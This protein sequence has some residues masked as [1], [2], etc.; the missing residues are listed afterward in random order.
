MI[1]IRNM[2]THDS[3]GEGFLDSYGMGVSPDS[4][5]SIWEDFTTSLP[6]H[7]WLEVIPF[8]SAEDS[9]VIRLTYTE[10][11]EIVKLPYAPATDSDAFVRI[12]RIP[13]PFA[14]T[15]SQEGVVKL[16][17]LQTGEVTATAKVDSLPVFGQINASGSHLAWRNPDS[18]ELHLLNFETGEDKLVANLDGEYIQFMFLT[19][20]ADVIIGVNVD[21]QPA[22]VAWDVASG[23]RYE[24]GEYRECSRVPDM[25]RLSKDGTTLVIGCD[26]G[27]DIWRI[28][29]AGEDE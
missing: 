8:D 5:I 22:V 11:D 29:Q 28:A 19:L 6:P 7:Y 12:G 17:N 27:L 18:Q 1:V 26:T 4:P 9:Y 15:S 24:L 10:P 2:L 3:Y 14:V 16:W 25:A 13:P 23:Q 20:D 21:F